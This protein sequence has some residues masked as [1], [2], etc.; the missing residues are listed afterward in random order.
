MNTREKPQELI[1]LLDKLIYKSASYEDKPSF[2]YIEKLSWESDKTELLVE[3]PG[4]GEILPE[5]LEVL[6]KIAVT[7]Y[8][9]RIIAYRNVSRDGLVTMTKVRLFKRGE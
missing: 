7:G 1:E 5:V 3:V 6:K 9:Y 2:A 4:E 8:Y